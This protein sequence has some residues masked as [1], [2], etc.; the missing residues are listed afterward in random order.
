MDYSASESAT[1]VLYNEQ[2]LIFIFSFSSPSEIF[3]IA[4]CCKIWNKSINY[5]GSVIWS[6][7]IHSL[8]K[9]YQ[10]LNNPYVFS[11]S[12][13]AGTI[14]TSITDRLYDINSLKLV[15]IDIYNKSNIYNKNNDDIIDD[16]QM[17]FMLN[18]INN[19][20]DLKVKYIILAILLFPSKW[21]T[22]DLL[23]VNE[24]EVQ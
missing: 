14:T 17:V 12:N 7:H 5:Y 15:L 22:T 10:Q 23:K 1:I 20:D 13:P 6:L 21:D 4:E 9:P 11:T 8:W 24:D 18:V 3:K 19:H 2:L 16:Q